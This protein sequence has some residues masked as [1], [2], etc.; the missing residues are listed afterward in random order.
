MLDIM[1][2]KQFSLQLKET[3]GKFRAD[4][5]AAFGNTSVNAGERELEKSPLK[6]GDLR[7]LLKFTEY[8]LCIKEKQVSELEKKSARYYTAALQLSGIFLNTISDE[9]PLDSVLIDLCSAVD[10]DSLIIWRQRGKEHRIKN[11]N[12]DDNCGEE[13]FLSLLPYLSDNNITDAVFTRDGRHIIANTREMEGLDSDLVFAALYVRDKGR[14][15][16][17]DCDA[18]LAAVVT[19]IILKLFQK[20]E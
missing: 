11:V 9:K 1:D 13:L 19:D 15:A 16:F 20:Q 4:L 8:L 14:T 3:I 12:I 5:N 7:H 10:A 6:E 2:D 17:E 18:A